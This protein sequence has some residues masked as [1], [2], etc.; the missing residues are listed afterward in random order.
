M[1]KF[2]LVCDSDHRFEGW[3]SSNDDFDKQSTAGLVCCPVCNSAKVEKAL[4][5]PSVST[6]KKKDA[7]MQLAMNTAQSAAMTQ[8]REAVKKIRDNSEDVGARF[9]EEA[10][11][12]HYG[13][14]EERG[15]IG[16][17][18]LDDAKALVEEGIGV[19]P[20]PDLPEDKN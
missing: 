20:L 18:T 10:R 2:N 19:A 4:M 12:I 13:E 14:A 7:A 16:Q 3:F 5:A 1:I 9:P 8:L 17:A 11:K 15:I 6:A